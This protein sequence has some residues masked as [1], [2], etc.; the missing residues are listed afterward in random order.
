M[1]IIGRPP[2]PERGGEHNSIQNIDDERLHVA[3]E[4]VYL[5]PARDRRRVAEEFRRDADSE[6]G[7][8]DHRWGC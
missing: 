3:N 8:I 7:K 5:V 1:S 6:G 2:P 4:D